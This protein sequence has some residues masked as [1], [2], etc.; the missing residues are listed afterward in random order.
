M[1]EILQ[2]KMMEYTRH[3]LVCVGERCTENSA[4]QALYEQLRDKF[5]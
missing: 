5:K 4:G 2:P 1:P 3:L